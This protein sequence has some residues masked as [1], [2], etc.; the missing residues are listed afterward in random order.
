[1]HRV[2]AATVATQWV[3]SESLHGS[4]TQQIRRGTPLAGW[5]HESWPDLYAE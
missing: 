2:L 4:A 3:L 5:A 1:M